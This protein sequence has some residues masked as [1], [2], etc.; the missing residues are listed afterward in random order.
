M[1][2]CGKVRKLNN[3]DVVMFWMSMSD[4]CK[5][6]FHVPSPA[7][8]WFIPLSSSTG[9]PFSRNIFTHRM[10]VRYRLSTPRLEH[11]IVILHACRVDPCLVVACASLTHA[12]S[13]CA[14]VPRVSSIV[15]M[16]SR[17]CFRAFLQ[18]ISSPRKVL[19]LACRFVS[20]KI[21]RRLCLEKH[22]QSTLRLH[23]VRDTNY[24]RHNESVRTC[25]NG[26]C[27]GPRKNTNTVMRVLGVSV[28]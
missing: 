12:A 13:I 7:F 11:A 20:V 22:A 1:S 9:T 21:S 23:S 3:C 15:I 14:R 27:G 16:S 10:V 6:A 8:P 2:M 26:S 18:S 17:M 19:Y 24:T 4:A 5:F 28:C 25:S